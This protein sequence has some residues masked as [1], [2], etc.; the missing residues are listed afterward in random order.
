[1]LFFFHLYYVVYS[2]TFFTVYCSEVCICSY[3]LFRR[4]SFSKLF[5][6]LCYGRCIQTRVYG[7]CFVIFMTIILITMVCIFMLWYEYSSVSFHFLLF[8]GGC[9]WSDFMNYS[10]KYFYSCCFQLY[11]MVDVFFSLHH[12]LIFWDVYIV[13]VSWIFRRLSLS[14]LFAS[15]Y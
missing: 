13:I 10:D 8:W 15:L 14:L 6:W 1:M 12:C 3:E 4:V 5:A 9:T 11:I 2:S 7:Y